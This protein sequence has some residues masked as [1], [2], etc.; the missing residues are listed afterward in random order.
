MLDVVKLGEFAMPVSGVTN[1]WNSAVAWRPEIG[2]IHEEQDAPGAGVFDEPV[3]EGAGGEGFARAGGHLDE[4]AGMIF[5]KGFFQGGD[6]LNLALAHALRGHRRQTLQAGAEGVGLSQPFGQ[7]FGA[8][9]TEHQPRARL[10]IA[11]VAEKSFDA[12]GFVKKRQRAGAVAARKSGRF[13]PYWPDC[14]A[15]VRRR[16]RSFLASR[17]PSGLRSTSNR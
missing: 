13:S 12:G 4:G 1:C 6:C 5:G 9:K 16:V 3:G 10:G 15:T 17:T 2:A 14:S 11:F 7:G 8:M